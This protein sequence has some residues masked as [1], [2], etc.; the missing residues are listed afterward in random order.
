MSDAKTEAMMKLNEILTK[1]DALS[2]KIDA[3]PTPQAYRAAPSGGPAGTTLPNYGRSAGAPIEGAPL[4][5][6]EF[7]A[8]GARRSLADPGKA[9]WHDKE[10][11]LLVALEAEIARQGNGGPPPHGDAD[12]PPAELPF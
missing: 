12:A 7:Y 10:K 11:A 5:D 1:L 9:R 6:L 8:N 3:R 4:Q 2:A